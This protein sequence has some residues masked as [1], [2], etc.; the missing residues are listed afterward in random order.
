M[1]SIHQKKCLFS[2]VAASLLCSNFASAQTLEAVSIEA[3]KLITPTKQANESVYTGSEVTSKGI[4]LQGVK[5]S[6][7]VYE[8]ISVLPGVNVENV[9]SSGLAVEQSSVRMRG[10][11][12]SMGALSVEGI[13]NYGGNPIGPRDYLYDMENMDSV[14]VYKGGVPSDIGAG[15]GSR[16]GAI[17]LHPK[18]AQKEFGFEVAQSLGS[19][20][21]TKSYFRMDSGTINESGTRFSGALSYAQA[22]K[23]RGEGELGP[24]INGNVSLVQP[25]GDKATL[26]LWYNHNDQEQYLYRPLSYAQISG[27]NLSRNYKND[28]NSNLTGVPA[29]DIYYYKN[30]KGSYK[31]DDLFAVINYE[32]DDTFE[33]I[34]KPYYALEDSVISQGVT[35]GGGRIQ[36]RVRDIER[37]GM[38][39][40]VDAKLEH[41]K[42]ALGYHY[43]S[44]AMDISTKNYTTAGAYAGMGVVATTGDTYIHSPYAKISGDEGDFHWQAGLKYFRFED[45][46]SLGYRSGAAPAYDL[47]RTPD[48]D[49]EAKSHA[50]WLPTLGVS[51]DVDAS[52]QAYANYGKNFIRP[53]SYM[54][55]V[56]YYQN[57]RAKFQAIGM[58]AQDLFDGYG[59]EESHNFDVGVRFK[60]EMLEIAP[61][62]FYGK[63]KNLLTTIINPLDATLSYQQNVGKATSYGIETEINFFMNDSTTLFINPTYTD[64]TYDEDII[65]MKTKGKQLVDTPKWMA[66]SGIIYK[67]GNFELVPMVRFLGE[68]YGNATNTEKVEEAWLADFKAIY[69][70]KNFY[71]KSTLKVSLELDNIFNKEYISVINASDYETGT[72]TYSQG[73]PRSVM[74]S[75]G[76]K[77]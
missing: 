39:S 47:I 63:H 74:L 77:F 5:A 13:P 65:G 36:E 43:E 24:R 55:L 17:T 41:F 44:S 32:I 21:Y 45:S 27:G 9:D 19:H 10:V 64:F 66:R 49:R 33:L 56:N 31:N 38:I 42:M 60:G 40:E 67:I 34:F 51:Y 12:S 18:W 48:L 4:E 76:L 6:T 59:I 69:T 72:T 28:Y 7:S 14:S 54:P 22:D 75:V 50:L 70:Q 61:T 73:A 3:E 68:R 37:Y 16:G 23:W 11:R 46:K 15:V 26:K 62:L 8:A 35:S 53:Y 29:Q 25:L 52:W 71:E 2:C 30:N 1:F 57:N 58:N 20:D